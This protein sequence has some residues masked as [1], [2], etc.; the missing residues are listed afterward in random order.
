MLS[1]QELHEIFEYKEGHLYWKKTM[2]N[3]VKAGRKAGSIRKD[4]YWKVR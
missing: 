4:G 1:K 2:S 3:F